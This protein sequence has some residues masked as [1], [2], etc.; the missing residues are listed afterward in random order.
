MG[1]DLTKLASTTPPSNTG[2]ETHSLILANGAIELGRTGLAIHRELTRAEWAELGV[3]L[4]AVETGIQWAQGDWILYGAKR[5]RGGDVAAA[6]DATGLSYQALSDITWVARRIEPSRRRGK[7]SFSHHREVAGL[8][9]HEQDSLLLAA[10]TNGW[11]RNRLRDE[12]QT[13]R[14]RIASRNPSTGEAAAE[15]T[16]SNPISEPQAE[17]APQQEG[18]DLLSELEHAH[19]RIA[20]QDALIESLTADDTA[21]ELRNAHEQLAQLRARNQTLISEK[22]EALK[23]A[24]YCEGLLRKIRQ[25]LGVERDRDIRGAIA[26]LIV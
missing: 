23:Q 2:A 3:Q 21:A 24:A 4:H 13:F 22:N 19:R 16:A 15:P 18:D 12:V 26:Q 25:A 14:K 17:S 20:E 7:L 11:S 6:V 8:E 9:P 10:E 1:N 5:T